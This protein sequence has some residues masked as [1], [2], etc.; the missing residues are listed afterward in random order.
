[1]ELGLRDK[2][3]IVTGA[4]RGLGRAIAEALA[5][6]GARVAMVDLDRAALEDAARAVAQR[7]PAIAVAADVGSDTQVREVVRQ[8]L[9]AYGT[10]DVLVNNAGI[11][12]NATLAEVTAAEWDRVMGVNL[13][14]VLLLSQAVF[15]TMV[16]RRRGAIINMASMA[17]KVGGLKVGPGYTASKA[18]I[19]GLTFSLART[20]AQYGIR[21]NALAPAFIESAMMPVEKRGEYVPL[22]PLGRMGTPQDVANA[23]LFLASDAA[24]YITGEVLDVNGGAHMD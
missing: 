14:S 17:A 4:A 12:S 20:G 22:I 8:V 15:P 1:M 7:A 5:G 19:I 13:R 11:S 10:I 16:A 21:V 2:V 24:G 9:D 6:E 23:V 3:A 18:G